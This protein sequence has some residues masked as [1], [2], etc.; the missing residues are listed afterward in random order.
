MKKIARTVEI[1]APDD[2]VW[3]VLVDFAAYPEWNPFV[4]SVAGAPI[5]GSRLKIRLRPAGRRGM[6]FRP[7]VLA[8]TPRRELRWLGRALIPGLFDGEHSFVIE[9]TGP[10]SCRLVQGETFRGLLVGLFGSGLAATAE[11]FNQMNQAL[12]D[13]AE[14]TEVGHPGTSTRGAM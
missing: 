5:V 4:T 8:A 14:Q 9:P 13:R 10:S 2:R 12:K 1:D 3:D 11:G 7:R 6:T